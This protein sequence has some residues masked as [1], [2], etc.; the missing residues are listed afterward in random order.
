MAGSAEYDAVVLDV[1]L[2]GIDGF[3]TCRRLREDGVWAPVLMLTARGAVE[4]RVAGLD[5][6]AD[7][8]LT[9][10]FSFAELFARLRALIRRGPERAA[11]V[12][13]LAICASIRPPGRHGEGERRSPSPPRSSPSSRRS[14]AGP[15]SPVPPA[16]ARAGLGVR[17]RAPLQRDRGLRSLPAPQD[18]QAVRGRVDRDDPRR[19]LPPA[20]GRRSAEA[21]LDPVAGDPGLR[22]GDGDRARRDRRL[23]LPALRRRARR[24]DQRR[25]ALACRRRGGP[26][27]G[28]RLG[29]EREGEAGWSGAR[30]ASPRCSTP[31][32]RCSIRP[33]RSAAM[34]CSARPSSRGPSSA[35]LP[36]PRA[37]AGTAGRVAA[38]GGAGSSAGP[39][40]G[41]GRRNVDRGRAASRR[42][43]WPSCCWSAARS[44]CCSPRWRP[45]ASP[46]RP[47]G[48]SRRCAPGRRRSPPP[49]P[50]QRLP[51]PPTHDEIARLGVT[52]N[53]MLG[54]LAKRWRT[55]GASSPT[56]ATSCARRW[57]SSRRSSIWPSA[58]SARRPSSG[59]RWPLPSEETDRLTQLAEDLLTIAQ[60][61]QGELPVRL[62]PT[63]V[64][65]LLR[66]VVRRF[67]RRA[68]EGG[69]DIE[70]SVEPGWRS[71]LTGCGSIRRWATCSTTPSVTGRGR[72]ASPRPAVTASSSFMSS[73]GAPASRRTSSAGPSSAS[74]AQMRASAMAEA[75]LG[76][77]SWPRSP[78]PIAARHTSPTGRAG[79]PT[80]G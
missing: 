28:G 6:G 56:P 3:E 10:P 37:P 17:L 61:D 30:R 50:D 44:R 34:F 52:L 79:E 57:R 54:R 38:A 74:A 23:R 59:R 63:D 77:R 24:H 40:A 78:A 76:S 51:V 25:P 75:A 72:S 13:R 1:I 60:T 39:A 2:P 43:T 14:C 62:A 64:G 67:S 41:R 5:G 33:A 42:R 68:E 12:S 35:G 11:R 55:S 69:R 31:R 73:I 66:G 22:A 45:T 53:A 27:Q 70:V 20:E 36:R 16:A 8:Y 49:Q 15:A 19:G 32:A 58:K 26:G 29:L 18:R 46:P 65:E 21:A 7:D 4:D 71:R 9:K 47:C 80:C 48:R